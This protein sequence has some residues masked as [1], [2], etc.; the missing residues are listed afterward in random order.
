VLN[1]L[2]I[3]GGPTK[4]KLLLKAIN[5]GFKL[6][7]ILIFFDYLCLWIYKAYKGGGDNSPEFLAGSIVSFLQ[8]LN[9]CSVVILFNVLIKKQEPGLSK[10]IVVIL[11]GCLVILNYIRYIWIA[12]FSIEAIDNRWTL[13][14]DSYRMR[15]RYLQTAY[16]I[17]SIVLFFG[18][19]FRFAASKM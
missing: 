10:L 19:V 9:I 3:I 15:A 12:K 11:F 2:Y 6:M 5:H 17:F 4:S 7:R 16:V 8:T 14:P 13:E 1:L 18:L